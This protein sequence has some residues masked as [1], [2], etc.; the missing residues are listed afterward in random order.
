MAFKSG[1]DTEV[2]LNGADISA[3]CNKADLSID[4]DVAE[5]DVFKQEWKK[6][7]AGHKSVSEDLG[8]Y[9]DP[10]DTDLRDTLDVAPG[11]VLTVA[12]AGVAAVGDGCRLSSIV[13]TTYKQ[14]SP[15]GGAVEFS[16]SGVCDGRVG[17]GVMYHPLAA[18][19]ED[20]EGTTVDNGAPTT[21]GAIAH[22]HVTSVS[23]GD[24]IDVS[25]EDSAN[26]ADWLALDDS[27]FATADAAGAERLEIPGTVREYVRVVWDIT[28]DD[29]S[30][31][32]AVALARL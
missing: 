9:Y 2:L 26:G 29:P 4:R 21:A 27:A 25:F 28:G 24:E 1:K 8:G 16:W 20:G 10:A 14:S 13:T 17:L 22:L 19:V 15:V 6:N 30:I 11:A 23:A 31:E 7:L 12:P 3:Y 5:V 18:E 32:F